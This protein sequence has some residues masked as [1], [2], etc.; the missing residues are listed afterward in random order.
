MAPKYNTDH[1]ASAH[2]KHMGICASWE[3][4]KSKALA[5]FRSVLLEQ[6]PTQITLLG[7]DR[8]LICPHFFYRLPECWK[9]TLHLTV[10][11][12][13]RSWKTLSTGKRGARLRRMPGFRL[14]EYIIIHML[15]LHYQHSHLQEWC[16]TTRLQLAQIPLYVLWPWLFQVNSCSLNIQILLSFL[17]FPA[18]GISLC[19][20]IHFFPQ[21]F[22]PV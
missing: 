18:L 19:F 14:S 10:R 21:E 5:E 11:A 13:P 6:K 8:I 20:S 4:V 9:S 1:R 17:P 7:S 22:L 12:S 2:G 3:Q 16:P 15:V